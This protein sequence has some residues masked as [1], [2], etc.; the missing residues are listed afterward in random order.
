[1]KYGP[2]AKRDL[3]TRWASR[4]VTELGMKEVSAVCERM[5]RRTLAEV[6]EFCNVGEERRTP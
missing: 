3:L 5:M 1:M 2:S 4:N 6:R